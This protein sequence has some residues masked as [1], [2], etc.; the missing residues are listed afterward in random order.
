MIIQMKDNKRTDF[1]GIFIT[2]FGGVLE[3]TLAKTT[4]DFLGAGFNT[5]EEWVNFANWIF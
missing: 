4:N 1:T 5:V 3:I 2:M